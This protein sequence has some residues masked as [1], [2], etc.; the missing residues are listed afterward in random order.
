MPARESRTPSVATAVAA[1]TNRPISEDDLK[2][3]DA[4]ARSM[5]RVGAYI[6]RARLADD[7]AELLADTCYRA[8]LGRRELLAA[9]YPTDVVIGH[10]REACRAC[11]AT[12]RYE[13]SLDGGTLP[14]T[15]GF[16]SSDNASLSVG[17][18]EEWQRWCNRVLGSLSRQQ[19]LAVDYRYRWS[20]SYELIAVAIGSTEATARVHVYRGLRRLRQLVAVDP[21]PC[22]ERDVHVHFE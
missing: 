11:M 9:P 15:T 20:W 19:R 10:A 13:R 7:V 17:E 3:L 2:W 12:Y 6:R 1:E 18:A 4:V 14:T 8:W 22:S 21:P 5:P 16:G